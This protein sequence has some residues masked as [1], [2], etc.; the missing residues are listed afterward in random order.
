MYEEEIT[1]NNTH[2]V[3]DIYVCVYKSV[4]AEGLTQKSSRVLFPVDR[5]SA[6]RVAVS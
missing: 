2:F 5:G 3:A 1:Y 6:A 4:R